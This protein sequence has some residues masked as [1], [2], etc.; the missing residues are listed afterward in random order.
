M[1]SH[2][3]ERNGLYPSVRFLPACRYLLPPVKLIVLRPYHKPQAFLS[4][5]G[6]YD[7]IKIINRKLHPGSFQGRNGLKS[8]EEVFFMNPDLDI[9]RKINSLA[10]R[11]RPFD[12]M[13]DLITRYGHWAFVIYGLLL[14]FS[15]GKDRQENRRCCILAFFGVCLASIISFVIGKIWF[16]KRPFTRDYRIWNFT[17]HKANASFPSNHTMNGAVVVLQLLS[18]HRKG[19]G[20]MTVMAFILAFSRLFSGVHYPSDLLGGTA[21]AVLVHRVLNHEALAPFFRFLTVIFSFISDE[22]VRKIRGR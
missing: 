6:D 15:P 9:V 14:W 21:V 4:N 13:M 17:G 11:V 12:L 22:A 8:W 3:L 18:M 1:G 19:S 16:R 10:G 7:K 20:I 2:G 5:R